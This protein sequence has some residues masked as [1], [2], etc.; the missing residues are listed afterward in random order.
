MAVARKR[1]HTAQEY[2]AMEAESEIRHEFI[3]GEIYAMSGGTA[4]HTE[5]IVNL[6]F[7]LEL[8][9]RKAKTPCRAYTQDLKVRIK[10][11]NMFAYPDLMVICGKLD[12]EPGR[13]DVVLNPT[14]IIEVSS[15]S[16]SRYDHTRKFAAYRQI[17]SLEE[18]LMIEQGHVYVECFRKNKSKLWV[19]EAYENLDETLRLQTVG[20]DVPVKAIYEQVDL[21]EEG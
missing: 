5:I 6:T 10:K 2:L 1:L 8:A 21:V 16:S 14:V 7:E 18:Y 19:L 3:N 20:V 4:A 9:L 15:H 11:A 13:K 17:P 12:F